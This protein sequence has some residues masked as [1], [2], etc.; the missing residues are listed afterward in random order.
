[1]GTFILCVLISIGLFIYVNV[2]SN[3]SNDIENKRTDALID[4]LRDPVI[5]CWQEVSDNTLKVKCKEQGG[6]W[7]EWMLVWEQEGRAPLT[8]YWSLAAQ[9]GWPFANN[10]G[11]V[12][13][14]FRS[15]NLREAELVVITHSTLKDC[16]TEN[17]CERV[18]GDEGRD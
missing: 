10:P 5:E 15:E 17:M 3:L 16:T 4:N 9:I 1:M 14:K 8:S 2:K 11:S 12:T 6:L 7:G 18:I 13:I